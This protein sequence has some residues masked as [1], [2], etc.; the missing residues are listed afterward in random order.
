[1]LITFLSGLMDGYNSLILRPL[2][3]AIQFRKDKSVT[4]VPLYQD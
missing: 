3:Y 4:E 1:M 2:R